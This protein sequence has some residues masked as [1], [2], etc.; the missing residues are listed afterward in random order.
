MHSQLTKK[1]GELTAAQQQLQQ[2]HQELTVLQVCSC[3]NKVLPTG[4][5]KRAVRLWGVVT[6]S[7]S[8][9]RIY[10]VSAACTE[11]RTDKAYCVV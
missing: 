10:C 9:P 4:K 1:T 2:Q 3:L 8:S 11:R 6:T 7:G 5:H